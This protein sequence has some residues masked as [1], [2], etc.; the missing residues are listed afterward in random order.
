MTAA[1]SPGWFER[2]MATVPPEHR[3]RE[4]EHPDCDGWR[5]HA[6]VAERTEHGTWR[7]VCVLGCELG[8]VGSYGSEA[9]ARQAAGSHAFAERCDGRCREW[10]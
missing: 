3:P 1:A 4:C 9:S 8:G 10:T 6:V 7:P 5:H 2:Y